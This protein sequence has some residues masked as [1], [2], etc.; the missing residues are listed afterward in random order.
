[1]SK[2]EKVKYTRSINSSSIIKNKSIFYER[3]KYTV[4]STRKYKSKREERFREL[5]NNRK[6][7]NFE[8]IKLK[9]I[10]GN[11]IIPH[12]YI[13]VAITPRG[14]IVCIHENTDGSVHPDLA[15]VVFPKHKNPIAKAIAASYTMVVPIEGLVILSH[16]EKPNKKR[17]DAKEKIKERYKGVKVI[18]DLIKKEQLEKLKPEAKIGEEVGYVER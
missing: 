2:D 12:D 16:E 15:K 9:F 10:R 3:I 7:T 14:S 5:N 18:D 11:Q 13:P 1:M 6:K 8:K 4:S 17:E